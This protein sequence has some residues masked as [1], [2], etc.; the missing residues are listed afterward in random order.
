M[1]REL[2]ILLIVESYLLDAT[3]TTTTSLITDPLRLPPPA[4]IK[5]MA[6]HS[7]TPVIPYI[8]KERK[9]ACNIIIQHLSE[10]FLHLV[11][12]VKHDPYKM[13]MVLKRHFEPTSFVAGIRLH[14]KFYSLRLQPHQAVDA[15]AAEIDNLQ[16]TINSLSDPRTPPLTDYNKI[17]IFLN[18]LSDRDFQVYKVCMQLLDTDSSQITW[19]TLV[20]TATNYQHNFVTSVNIP[21]VLTS[22]AALT[23]Q[24]HARPSSAPGYKPTVQS[25]VCVHWQRKG[26]CRNGTRCHYSHPTPSPQTTYK[27]CTF[28]KRTGHSVDE[29]RPKLRA[30]STTSG[31]STTGH[32]HT[33]KSNQRRQVANA[34]VLSAEPTPPDPPHRLDPDWASSNMVHIFSIHA[35]EQSLT[36]APLDAT[37]V[38]KYAQPTVGNFHWLVD[39]GA[40]HTF[41]CNLHLL[42]D[43]REVPSITIKAAHGETL[44]ATLVGSV[45]L[46]TQ[47]NNTFYLI[48][49]T[50]VIYAPSLEYNILSG[51]SV[52]DNGYGLFLYNNT[53]N[54]LFFS[55]P[56]SFLCFLEAKPFPFNSNFIL[57]IK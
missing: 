53:I 13:W 5:G 45:H 25:G 38:V 28:C 40:S 12:P 51:N 11:K 29:C 56:S 33:K 3:T 4:P 41:C 26:S 8:S 23:S 9:I 15:F 35:L 21:S 39:T 42:S 24:Q 57:L 22:A 50:N 54:F 49:L 37:D 18:G 47:V 1:H 6:P 52:A 44:Q 30:A 27:T 31:S 34:S 48:T 17:C 14:L 36:F 46:V 19:Q 32:A 16:S 10:F 2:L 55:N 20:Q 7:V 43:A